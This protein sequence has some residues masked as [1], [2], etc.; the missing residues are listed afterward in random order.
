MMQNTVNWKSVVFLFVLVAAIFLRTYHFNDWLYFKMDQARD[1]FLIG[2]AV[3]NGPEHLPLLGARAGATEVEKGYL[4]LGPAYYYFQY[5]SGALFN[6]TRPYVFAYPDLFFSIIVI[7]LLYVFLRL[8]FSSWISLFIAS[9]YALSF[10]IIQYSRFAWN[11]NALPFFAILVFFGLLKFLNSPDGK[12][13]VIW[14]GLWALGLSIG[15]QLH[16]FG[17]F[18]LAGISAMVLFF[19]YQAWNVKTFFQTIAWK[20]I[21]Q[22]GSVALAVFLFLYSPVIISDIVKNGENSINLISALAN[23]PSDKPLMEKIPE[24]I[25]EQLKYYCLIT[26]SSCYG[27]TLRDNFFPILFTAV[28]FLGGIAV[29]VFL[30]KKTLPGIR[31]D[32]LALVVIWAGVFFIL[33]IPVAFQLRPRFFIVVFAVPFILL[34][35]I[36]EY[37]EKIYPPHAKKIAAAITLIVIFSNIQ[38][39]RAW[40]REQELSQRKS[41]VPKRTLIL[42]RKDGITLGQMDNAISYMYSLRKPDHTLYFYSKSEY[43]MPVKYLLFSKNDP[44]LVYFPLKLNGDPKAQYFSIDSVRNEDK[45]LHKKYGNS[46]TILSSRQ[47]GQLVVHELEFSNRDIKDNF[48]FDKERRKSDRIF[49]EDIFGF[50]ETDGIEIEGVE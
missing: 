46:F 35:F 43:V 15:S 27:G 24:N 38:G 4:R 22:Y 47:F 11:P 12:K 44:A 36:F 39:T 40:F 26:T 42:K 14:I 28:I 17:F 37:L 50:K 30:W 13:R 18:A 2:N 1:A 33:S 29:T 21:F 31:K 25:S 23:K 16:F 20:K 10:I 7:P 48:S 3:E 41:I 19:H 34:G 49:W 32:F 9:M 8:Y 45:A 5:L 6:S